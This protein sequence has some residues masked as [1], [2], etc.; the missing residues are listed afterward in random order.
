MGKPLGAVLT[1]QSDLS[2]LRGTKQM[3]TCRFEYILGK[4]I[5]K[6]SRYVCC[7]L[8]NSEFYVKCARLKILTELKH[9]LSVKCEWTTN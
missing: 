6:S 8:K 4:A 5:N 7:I 2:S 9:Q 1:F 3:Q